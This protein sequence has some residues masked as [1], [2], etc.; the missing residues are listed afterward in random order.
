MVDYMRKTL[1]DTYLYRERGCVCV[2]GRADLACQ[3]S[4]T[5]DVPLRHFSFIGHKFNF[6]KVALENW[7]QAEQFLNLV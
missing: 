7:V 5:F 1:Q 4:R 6:Q 3:N 2:R